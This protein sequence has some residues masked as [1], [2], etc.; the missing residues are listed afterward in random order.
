VFGL[1]D[2][3]SRLGR[4]DG[5]NDKPTTVSDSELGVDNELK[6]VIVFSRRLCD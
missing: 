6:F 1:S 2:Y 3:D 5:D 4:S